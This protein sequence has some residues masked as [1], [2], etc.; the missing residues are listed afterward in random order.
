MHT[1]TTTTAAAAEPGEALRVV[2]NDGAGRRGRE[3]V[4]GERRVAVGLTPQGSK[5]LGKRDERLGCTLEV[6]C[7]QLV[8]VLDKHHN[9]DVRCGGEGDSGAPTDSAGRLRTVEERLP[10]RESKKD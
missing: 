10:A 7:Q 3:E 2:S 9:I 6:A 1:A 5:L 8:L 4:R